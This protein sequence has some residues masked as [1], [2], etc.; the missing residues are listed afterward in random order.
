MWVNDR[1]LNDEDIYSQQILKLHSRRGCR[2]DVGILLGSWPLEIVD[3]LCKVTIANR[4]IF[5]I[6]VLAPLID[7]CIPSCCNCIRVV[8]SELNA[9]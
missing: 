6:S 8:I 3:S 2:E 9:F 1:Y 4:V 5:L 7:Y